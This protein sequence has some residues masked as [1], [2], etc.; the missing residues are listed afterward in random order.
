MSHGS[1]QDVSST[2]V[3]GRNDI[4]DA[5]GLDRFTADLG[6][7]W[8]ALIHD[9]RGKAGEPREPVVA[10]RGLHGGHHHVAVVFVAFGLDDADGKLGG[11][12]RQLGHGLMGQLVAVHQHQRPTTPRGN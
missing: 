1:G 10:V 8:E 9:H 11:D 7:R 4:A 3:V 5:N 12:Q 6:S 2:F